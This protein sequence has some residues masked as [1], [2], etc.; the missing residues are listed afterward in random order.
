[1]TSLM[2]AAP[3]RPRSAVPI[4][5]ANLRAEQ[6]TGRNYLSYSQLSLMRLCPRRFAFQYVEKAPADF[7]PSSLLFGG[8]IHAAMELYYRAQL[9]GL[10]VTRGALL[11]AYHDAWKKGQARSGEVVS[12]RFNKDETLDSLHLLADRMLAAFLE[13]SLS[14]PK[15]AI[16]GIEEELRV[17]LDPSLPDLLAK[18]DLVT[19]T[20]G[21]LHVV[22]FKTSRSRW[23]EA[24]AV[25]AGEQLI[26]YGVTVARMSRS[27]GLPVRLHFAV[28]TKA[29]KPVV[30]LLAVPAEPARLAA[31]RES[32]G[33]VWQAICVGNF[34]PNPSPQNCTTCP[35]RRQCPVFKRS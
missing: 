11:S 25:E 27:L 15:G 34:Y 18:V 33:Q 14:Q 4:R 30:Q 12:V 9:E 5:A 17:E 2:V 1:M 26:L 28:L 32:V 21:A 19:S 23:T 22:D 16:L 6:I 13:S 29:K 8:A 3:P 31:V 7:V 35:F 10:E 20:D 24:K